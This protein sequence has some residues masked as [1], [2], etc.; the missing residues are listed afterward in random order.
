VRKGAARV[1]L[2][3]FLKRT[4]KRCGR[5][6]KEDRDYAAMDVVVQT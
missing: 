6:S 3:V 1:Q 4:R 2:E 5:S